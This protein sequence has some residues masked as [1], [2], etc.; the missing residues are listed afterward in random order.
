MHLVFST[1]PRVLLLSAPPSKGVSI[2]L[3]KR[4]VRKIN[5][6]YFII[7][8]V[9][10]FIVQIQWHSENTASHDE[11]RLQNIVCQHWW[12]LPD[13]SVFLIKL[14]WWVLCCIIPQYCIPSTG[15]PICVYCEQQTADPQITFCSH[16]S[17]FTKGEGIK[18]PP[19]SNLCW[20]RGWQWQNDEWSMTK[21]CATSLRGHG[22]QGTE[23]HNSGKSSSVT[24]WKLL[25][26]GRKMW[27]NSGLVKGGCCYCTF[28][29]A[30]NGL[31]FIFSMKCECYFL[32]IPDF[33]FLE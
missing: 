17:Q 25:P 11:L 27:S 13:V 20:Y 26:P 3:Y 24:S 23:Y 31:Q 5:V 8:N 28:R 7:Y 18:C 2:G 12:C 33:C 15:Q 32:L 21:G 10:I 29:E 6:I 4:S 30:H 1:W 9:T 19:T 16:C 22:E 14:T